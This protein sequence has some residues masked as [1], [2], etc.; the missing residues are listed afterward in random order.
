MYR[1]SKRLLYLQRF[2]YI[3]VVLIL[4]NLIWCCNLTLFT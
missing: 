3:L 4:I 2:R 1:L